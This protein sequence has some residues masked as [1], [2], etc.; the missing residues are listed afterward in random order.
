MWLVCGLLAACGHPAPEEGPE[1]ATDE[2]PT[3]ATPVLHS[4]V[5]T[6]PVGAAPQPWALAPLA[7]PE[8][9]PWTLPAL[10][11]DVPTY[12]LTIPKSTLDQ[13]Y[14]D[15]WTTERPA[16]FSA[17]GQSWPVQVRL[18]GRSSRFFP[19]KS[20]RV[21]FGDDVKFDGRRKLNLIGMYQ[22]STML[23]EK[24]A[25][26]LL[27]AMGG[28]ATRAKYVRLVINGEYQGVYLDVE[29]VDKHFLR[30][31]G[32]YKDSNI[33]RCGTH[34]CEMKL[35]VQPYQ[36]PFEKK[37]NEDEPSDD[38][39]A[40]LA[41]INH[42][43]EP[44]FAETLWSSFDVEAYALSM[45]ADALMSNMT[46]EDS[47]SYL[48][49]DRRAGKW[50]YVP[51]D[52]NNANS[53]FWP[54]YP[55]GSSPLVKHPIFIFAS[56][57]TWILK[58]HARRS[59]DPHFKDYLPA[60]SNLTTR[61]A[62]NPVLKAHALQTLERALDELFVE[63]AM[64]AHIDGL[65]ALIAPHMADDPH[66]DNAA[67]TA[68]RKYMKQYVSGRIDFLRDE[69]D[70]LR[71]HQSP[72]QISAFDPQAGFIELRNASDQ[73]VSTGGLSVRTNLRRA[74]GQNVPYEKLE[75]GEAVRFTESDLGVKFAARGEVG[76]FEA[77]EVMSSYDLLFYGALEP[78]A[79]YARKQSAPGGWEIRR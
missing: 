22:D 53:R 37:T 24:L 35:F 2:R 40:F 48:V 42:T 32:I 63:D 57:D 16:T 19:K 30:A 27:Q 9:K 49:H 71:S 70:R 7:P 45:A 50:L 41:L 33:Y 65:H 72:I 59:S 13:F 11:Q 25:L 1:T 20:W 34:D 60:F 58:V 18:R 10:Q 44:L 3:A 5:T 14:R 61:F 74:A 66:I 54:T 28:P 69:L 68:G 76:V 15:V 79:W 52:Y 26:D 73:P 55:V 56:D 29:A 38:L 46:V 36:T 23:A 39:E 75:P 64:H 62:Q 51:W 78:G 67:F 17:D 77:G 43:P 21:E 4:A 6:S 8:V 31:R 12:E 47:G